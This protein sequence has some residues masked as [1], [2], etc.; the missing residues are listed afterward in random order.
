MGCKGRV[1]RHAAI[2]EA[3]R[4]GKATF[5]LLAEDSFLCK[6]FDNWAYQ[7]A[8]SY[9][10]NSVKAYCR[11]VCILINF[12]LEYARRKGG[13]TPL[14]LSNCLDSFEDYLVFGVN[15]DQAI[16]KEVATTLGVLPVNGSSASRYIV[17]ANKFM[18]ASEEFRLGMQELESVG[19]VS[20]ANMSA[21]P[22]GLLLEGVAP[23]KIRN[24][25]KDNSWFAGCL[26]GGAKRIKYRNLVPKSKASQIASTDEF[27]G[28]DLAFP[29]DLMVSLIES[30]TCARDA[31]LWS[32]CAA[33]G[34]RITEILSLTFEDVDA[35][36]GKV[37]IVDPQSRQK[38]LAMWLPAEEV[39]K[40]SHKCR[41]TPDTYGIEPF[42]SHF[43]VYY[44]KYYSEVRDYER[45]NPLE[46]KHK[47]IFRKH[48]SFEPL[49]NSYQAVYEKF[50]VASHAVTGRY[51]GLHSMRHMYGYY[52]VNFCPNPSNPRRFGL[53]IRLVQKFM[54]H[55]SLKS[56]MRYARKDA[57][58][59]EATLS[60][61]NALRMG[62]SQFS[63]SKVRLEHINRLRSELNEI[64][65]EGS[66]D[67]SDK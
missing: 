42:A 24:A 1:I 67:K 40:L 11:D 37:F 60:A 18:D 52:L 14:I 43:W 9:A 25:I 31:L 56:T 51:Y 26:A 65:L 23:L 6:F 3:V 50:R 15:S 30:A 64:L 5:V 45:L 44:A 54:G 33:F 49:I 20:H 27:G 10:F 63:V 7:L 2:A 35:S 48:N 58:M 17:S 16:I 62:V 61:L 38:E 41:D 39:K 53:D 4:N 59:L 22:Q 28:D 29:I 46:P 47:F 8:K 36:T 21:F 34:P 32:G 57:R 55:K 13:L 19:Y 66:N 12:I